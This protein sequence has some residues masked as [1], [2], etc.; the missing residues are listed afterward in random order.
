MAGGSEGGAWGEEEAGLPF[1]EVGGVI[2]AEGTEVKEGEVGGLDVGDEESGE[3]GAEG[4]GEE[5]AVA[6]E[7][8]EEFLPPRFAMAVGGLGGVVG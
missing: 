3:G 1:E 4:V 7:V 8:G 5:V 6:G 2:D